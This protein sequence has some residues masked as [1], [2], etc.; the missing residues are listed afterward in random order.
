[1]KRIF[2]CSLLVLVFPVVTAL[3]QPNSRSN[4]PFASVAFAGHTVSGGYCQCRFPGCICD[5]DE[6]IESCLPEHNDVQQLA[7]DANA[8]VRSS[9]ADFP[10]AALFL[11]TA[12]LILKLLRQ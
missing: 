10:S 5:P 12:L 4:A 11:G 2:A 9:D 7:G 3:L 1:M 6:S 8:P